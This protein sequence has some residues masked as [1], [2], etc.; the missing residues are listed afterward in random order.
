MQC[1]KLCFYVTGLRFISSSLSLFI[2]NLCY[3]PALQPL[4]DSG[5][6][7]LTDWGSRPRLGQGFTGWD[8]SCDEVSLVVKTSFFFFTL[9]LCSSYKVDDQLKLKLL[10]GLRPYRYV[11]WN[12]AVQSLAFRGLCYCRLLFMPLTGLL[13]NKGD[14]TDRPVGQ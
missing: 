4:T 13:N 12:L 11:D 8:S 1:A 9:S 5:S 2:I 6:S 14:Q 3:V 10:A 7:S